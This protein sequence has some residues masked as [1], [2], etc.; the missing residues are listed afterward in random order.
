MYLVAQNSHT[1]INYRRKGSRNY[2]SLAV[3]T[4]LGKS[5]RHLCDFQAWNVYPEI[6]PLGLVLEKMIEKSVI[7]D[8]DF[9]EA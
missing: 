6:V 1:G 9:G 8:L 2:H 5:R 7:Y 4:K 3:P